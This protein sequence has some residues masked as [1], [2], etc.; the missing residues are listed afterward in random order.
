MFCNKKTKL[1]LCVLTSL[2]ILTG[3]KGQAKAT[4]TKV[5]KT[6]VKAEYRELDI[7]RYTFR[8]GITTNASALEYKGLQIIKPINLQTN[9]QLLKSKQILKEFK[10]LPKT[11]SINIKQIQLLDYQNAEDEYWAQT[12]NMK[13]LRSY[14]TGADN[15]IYFYANEHFTLERNIGSLF[16]TLLHESSHLLDDKMAIE[17]K[18]F[19]DSKEWADVMENDLILKD[20]S[21]FGLYCSSY[22]QKSESNTED[23]AEA[24]MY[25]VID[26]DNFTENYPCRSKKIEQILND[27]IL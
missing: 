6:T 3:Y 26:K 23:F 12:Y 18:R 27:S 20:V 15:K 13:D 10:K 25:F 19:S 21:E 7:P 1:G 2:L 11:L 22:S 4:N 24:I 16:P 5:I 17:N 14:A 9:K 8:G